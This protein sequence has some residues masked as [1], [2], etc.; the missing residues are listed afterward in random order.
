MS[1]FSQKQIRW[2][3]NSPNEQHQTSLT[4]NAVCDGFFFQ[5][6]G[7]VA[8]VWLARFWSEI[9]IRWAARAS[10]PWN[11]RSQATAFPIRLVWR[12]FEIHYWWFFFFFFTPRGCPLSCGWFIHFNQRFFL[13]AFLDCFIFKR[14][15]QSE[16]PL[17]PL[18]SVWSWGYW[19]WHSVEWC[20]Y[21][22]GPRLLHYVSLFVDL[23]TD[24]TDC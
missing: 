4:G 6:K 11:H 19:P 23:C 10:E 1:W 24:L 2:S 7:D 14:R 12:C 18:A 9:F 8:P 3:S 15:R 21:G 22:R 16:S 17:L 13:F 5:F 20:T